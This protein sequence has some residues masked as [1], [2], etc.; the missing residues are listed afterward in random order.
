MKESIGQYGTRDGKALSF[1]K[2]AGEKDIIVYLHGVESSSV[3][4]KPLA[5]PLNEKGYTLYGIDR[6]GSGLNTG[7]RGDIGDYNIFLNDIEDALTFVKE[8]NTGKKIYLIGICWGALLAVNYAVSRKAKLDGLILL[9]PAIYRKVSFNPFVKTIA[10]ICF[11]I[12]PQTHFKIPIEDRMFTPNK[13]CLDFIRGDSMRLRSLT[14]RFFNEIV[15]MENDFSAIN[16]KIA[17]PIAVLLAGHDEIVDNSKT[18]QWFNRLD[19]RDKTIK[20]FKDFHHV[21][22]FEK[23]ASRLTD[24]ISGWLEEREMSLE[25]QSIKN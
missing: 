23:D 9:S 8:Q 11:F 15:K 5:V 3:W 12:N 20:V 10:K 7:E 22:P 24:F 6:R 4:F 17:S 16:H 19:S 14:V 2:W 13:E 21:M 1:R 18:R 25:G